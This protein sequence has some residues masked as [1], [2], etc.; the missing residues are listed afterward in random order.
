MN[1]R[2]EYLQKINNDLLAKNSLKEP[3]YA[4]QKLDYDV[5]F[6]FDETLKKIKQR[7]I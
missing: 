2:R 1:G 7:R 5:R 3:L 4:Y 6:K